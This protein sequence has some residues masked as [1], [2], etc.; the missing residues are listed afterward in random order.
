MLVRKSLQKKRG[1]LGNLLMEREYQLGNQIQFPRIQS[2]LKLLIK[3]KKKEE[4][5]KDI[6]EVL[7]KLEVNIPLLDLLE[8]IKMFKVFEGIMH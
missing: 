2:S 1:G 8:M 6:I 5:G 3:G 4:E 7:K